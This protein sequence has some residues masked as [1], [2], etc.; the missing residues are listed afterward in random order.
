LRCCITQRVLGAPSQDAAHT[1][2]HTLR[3]RLAAGCI[4]V[5][6]SEGLNHYFYLTLRQSVAALI[7][8]RWAS[9]QQ[10]AQ[11]LLHREWWRGYYHFV[12]MHESLR[13]RLAQPIDRA[14][15]RRPQR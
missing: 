9:M 1:L 3:Q 5:F 13:V 12:R 11:L 14:G 6:T 7:R 10:A 8:P 4:A 2:V 15:K